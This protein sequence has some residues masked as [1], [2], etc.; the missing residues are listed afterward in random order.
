[1]R[2]P[3]RRVLDGQV[4]GSLGYLDPYTPPAFAINNHKE[5]LGWV[6]RGIGPIVPQEVDGT[7][8]LAVARVS[9]NLSGRPIS[10]IYA[11]PSAIGIRDFHRHGRTTNAI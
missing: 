5:R 2:E 8:P 4:L 3:E 11:P 9:D 10:G 7:V 6:V 1:M